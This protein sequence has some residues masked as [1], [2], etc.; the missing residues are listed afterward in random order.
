MDS[1]TTGTK[2]NP[3]PHEAVVKHDTKTKSQHVQT[4]TKNRTWPR[5]ME[6][7]PVNPATLTGVVLYEFSLSPL[8]S[9]SRKK[10]SQSSL[11]G[12]GVTTSS[13]SIYS[14]NNNTNS[15][16]SIAVKPPT[17]DRS[18]DH[19]RA[20]IPLQKNMGFLNKDKNSIIHT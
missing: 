6:D 1:F 20:R 19:N 8:P 15:Y 17:F 13:A 9:C 7:T 11:S 12:L 14:L 18:T 16:L 4:V 3:N 10:H 5:A 2:M